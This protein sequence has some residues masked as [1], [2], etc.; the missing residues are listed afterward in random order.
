MSSEPLTIRPSPPWRG[1]NF[2]ELWEFRDL[3]LILGRRDIQLRYRQTALGAAWVGVDGLP[4]GMTV[5]RTKLIA[6]LPSPTL[7]PRAIRPA[8]AA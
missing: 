4:Q 2:R 5:V 8:G 3:I 7:P 6:K 1:V